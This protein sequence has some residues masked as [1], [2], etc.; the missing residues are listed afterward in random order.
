MIVH[1]L[2]RK[3]RISIFYF[4]KIFKTFLW[5]CFAITMGRK[6]RTYSSMIISIFSPYSV[7]F[8]RGNNLKIWGNETSK[9]V[10]WPNLHN[11]IIVNCRNIEIRIG[12]QNINRACW[13]YLVVV[14]DC[15]Q[16]TNL[17]LQSPVK[18]V[19]IKLQ[20]QQK[21]KFCKFRKL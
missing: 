1:I 18:E 3:L 9:I 7:V 10:L 20:K 4:K 11:D 5:S 21:G 14:P 13:I 8:S 16:F 2:I 15:R 19:I 12:G 6:D 17:F